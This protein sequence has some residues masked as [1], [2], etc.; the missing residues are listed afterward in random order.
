MQGR[1]DCDFSD[2]NPA[3]QCA[4]GGCNGGLLCDPHT[5]TVRSLCR[6]LTPLNISLTKHQGVP[7]ATVAEFTFEGDGNR[8][9]FDGGFIPS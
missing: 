4:D 9:F 5:G 1:R 8:D 2:P 3:T 7:P 6:I